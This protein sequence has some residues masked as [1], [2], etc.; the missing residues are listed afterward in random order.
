MSNCVYLQNGS[1]AKKACISS[2]SHSLIS[3]IKNKTLLFPL[4]GIERCI[5]FLQTCCFTRLVFLN[6]MTDALV[7][8]TRS[9]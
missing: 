1:A 9:S 4:Y 5:L 7:L 2:K 8:V 6:G 3:E